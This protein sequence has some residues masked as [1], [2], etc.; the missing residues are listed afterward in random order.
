MMAYPVK[1]WHFTDHL[2]KDCRIPGYPR[3]GAGTVALPHPSTS[4]LRWCESA[5]PLPWPHFVHG[6]RSRSS[7]RRAIQIHWL[8]GLEKMKAVISRPKLESIERIEDMT[9][10]VWTT[11]NARN[12]EHLIPESTQ[13]RR[14]DIL[15]WCKWWDEGTCKLTC[16][17]LH[18][19][20]TCNPQSARLL[21]QIQCVRM[22]AHCV[23]Q[24]ISR[25]D[26]GERSH[27]HLIVVRLELV[28]DD[29]P[30]W[31][32]CRATLFRLVLHQ[33]FQC[34]TAREPLCGLQCRWYGMD[35]RVTCAWSDKTH[36]FWADAAG[37]SPW[38]CRWTGYRA[39]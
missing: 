2:R 14:Y 34:G 9:I 37:L 29:M 5:N 25:W 16:M 22:M 8:R 32:E 17:K 24:W 7:L 15:Q 35:P 20:T 28:L 19:G 11:Y 18:E 38:S 27:A 30:H 31:L 21:L 6:K 3:F 10:T 1:P 36:N 33:D 26:E 13:R 39:A 4:C 12:D 23:K